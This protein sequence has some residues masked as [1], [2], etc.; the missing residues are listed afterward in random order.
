MSNIVV[1]TTRTSRWAFF[2]LVA[3]V[4]LI[5]ALWAHYTSAASS[6]PF[7]VKG[8]VEKINT[9][10]NRITVYTPHT[11]A[12]ATA[13]MKN[14]THTIV[15]T[16]AA[17]YEWIN[18]VKQKTQSSRFRVGHEVVIR[19]MKT[20]GGT[21]KADWIVINDRGFTLTGRVREVDTELSTIKVLIGNSTYKPATFNNKEVTL[22]YR[23]GTV[24]KR[25]GTTVG[26]QSVAKRNQLIKVQGDEAKEGYNWIITD[27]WDSLPE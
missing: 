10:T 17:L 8:R 25:L 27:L 21:F 6:Y 24:C 20:T 9:T 22:Q 26:C 13:E 23:P 2:S 14:K 4:L 16:D 5:T 19:G 3:T 7:L 11:S 15:F 18:G 12:A 1:S